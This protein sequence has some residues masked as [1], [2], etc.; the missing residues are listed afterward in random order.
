[1]PRTSH[2]VGAEWEASA[3]MLQETSFRGLE[4]R[5]LLVSLRCYKLLRLRTCDSH[6]RAG[7]P[8]SCSVARAVCFSSHEAEHS[9]TLT[10]QVCTV[11]SEVLVGKRSRKCFSIPGSQERIRSASFLLLRSCVFTEQSS[12]RTITFCLRAAGAALVV[13]ASAFLCLF[14]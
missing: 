5:C 9:C 7:S 1:M 8:C 14:L 3:M 4:A 10:T 6:L 12:R 13:F 2:L 11:R